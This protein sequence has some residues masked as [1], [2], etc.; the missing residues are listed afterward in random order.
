MTVK[1]D[2]K[3]EKELTCRY[4]IDMRI[5][6]NF[7]QSTCKNFKNLQILK[8]DAKFKGKIDLCFQNQLEESSKFSQAEK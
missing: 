1:N 7:H 8:I 2:A 6:M 3:F 4:K 5:L